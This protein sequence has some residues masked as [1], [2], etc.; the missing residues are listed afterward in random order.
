MLRW[1]G[2]GWSRTGQRG[3]AVAVDAAGTPWFIAGDG[4]LWR[5]KRS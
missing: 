5:R 3:I 2:R 1:S 4:S